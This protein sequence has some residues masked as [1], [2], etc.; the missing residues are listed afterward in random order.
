MAS[1]QRDVVQ[2]IEIYAV[3]FHY[4]TVQ[5]AQEGWDALSEAG[6][7]PYYRFARNLNAVRNA[8]TDMEEEKITQTS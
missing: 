2:P 6:K 1:Q 4:E 5:N 8:T 3:N 7:R